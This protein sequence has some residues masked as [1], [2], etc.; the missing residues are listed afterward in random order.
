MR[1]EKKQPVR[2]EVKTDRALSKE[3][4]GWRI[5][6]NPPSEGKGRKPLKRR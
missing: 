5:R 4:S 1:D 3:S 6:G 2:G